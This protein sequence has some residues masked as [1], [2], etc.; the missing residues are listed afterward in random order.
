MKHLLIPTD[1]SI[2]SLNAIH[3]AVSHYKGEKIKI[4]LFHLLNMPGGIS[5]LLFRTSR[6]RHYDMVS[7]EFHEACQVLH[8]RHSSAI[9]S[10][11]IKFGAGSTVSYL[12][13]FLEGEKV[14]AAIIC[15]DIQL[16]AAS[17]KS[18]DAVSLLKRTGIRIEAIPSAI[19]DKQYYDVDS[20]NM[21]PGNTIK[22]PKKDKSYATE[23]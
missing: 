13:N 8:N 11:Q 10:I 20:I 23:E 3:A 21:L 14:D 22:V 12:Q 6:N 15:P 1:F 5:D 19:N 17:A 4:T 16:Q 2:K 7:T 18:V 9:S